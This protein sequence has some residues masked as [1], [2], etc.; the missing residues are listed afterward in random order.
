MIALLKMHFY[1]SR[2]IFI[3]VF[4]FFLIMIGIQWAIIKEVN[5]GFL[6]LYFLALSPALGVSYLLENHFINRFRV[7]PIDPKTFVKSLFIFSLLLMLIITVPIGIYQT[8]LYLN[9]QMGGIELSLISIVFAAGIASIGSML[10]NYLSN[11]TKGTKSI[12]IGTIIGYFFIF[13]FVHLLIMLIFSILD[14]ELIG[15]PIVPVL[16]LIVYYRYF[17]TAI[18]K[19]KAAEF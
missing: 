3:T 4:L 1:L 19:F 18:T 12:S 15:A 9:N 5:L 2:K 11:P 17:K 8:Y 13:T 16:G 7:M 6:T 10:K 14:I